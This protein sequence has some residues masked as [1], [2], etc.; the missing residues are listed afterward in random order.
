MA[1]PRAALMSG[2]YPIPL[3]PPGERGR[4][5]LSA[6]VAI[7]QDAQ[8]SALAAG[9]FGL[10]HGA[11]G[12]DDVQ[13]LHHDVPVEQGVAAVAAFTVLAID[14]AHQPPG[15][16]I[17]RQVACA[18][19]RYAGEES[20]ERLAADDLL[21]GGQR[22]AQQVE[23]ASLAV[24]AIVPADESRAVGPDMNQRLER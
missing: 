4:R 21:I 13:D 10:R 12:D 19:A 18:L 9:G 16:L 24:A 1:G 14:Q 20:R 11:L 8:D 22:F 15:G 6:D 7:A 3:S 2:V 17:F 23:E 5:A